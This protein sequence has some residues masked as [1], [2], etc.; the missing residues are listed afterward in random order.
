ML[1]LHNYFHQVQSGRL[2]YLD[3]SLVRYPK[4]ALAG[5]KIKYEKIVNTLY[6]KAINFDLFDDKNL[7]NFVAGIPVGGRSFSGMSKK[8]FV[9]VSTVSEIIKLLLDFKH[10]FSFSLYL[11]EQGTLPAYKQYD[12]LG[13]IDESCYELG[14]DLWQTHISHFQDQSIPFTIEKSI[15]LKEKQGKMKVWNLYTEL[16][17]TF[18]KIYRSFDECSKMNLQ[19]GWGAYCGVF[20]KDDLPGS[21]VLNVEV[22]Q[23]NPID[24]NKA[25][26]FPVSLLDKVFHAYN[27]RGLA[28]PASFEKIVL[29]SADPDL[30]STILSGLSRIESGMI[31]RV[32]MP[33][34]IWGWAPILSL[35]ETINLSRLHSNILL[36]DASTYPEL[37]FVVFSSQQR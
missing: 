10:D 16:S 28:D 5:K 12:L 25:P 17:K 22:L 2:S 29:L 31:D 30:T 6:Q 8:L 37:T 27:D 7:W 11:D 35:F 18:E 21:E 23:L 36:I 3:G 15:V 24:Y 34:I 9:E 19:T 13:W 33:D 26:E 20:G 14:A 1:E 4:E 32:Y